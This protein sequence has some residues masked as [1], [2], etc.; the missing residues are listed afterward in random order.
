MASVVEKAKKIINENQDLFSTLEEL[1]RTGKLRKAK[2]KERATFT[3]D[4]D[5]MNRFRSY[6]RKNSMNMSKVVEDTIKKF[7]KEK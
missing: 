1:D 6:C 2:Y 3:V 7:L 5:L 4:E